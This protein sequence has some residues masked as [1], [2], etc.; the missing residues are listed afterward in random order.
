MAPQ[1][2]LWRVT[3][4]VERTVPANNELGFEHVDLWHGN[5]LMDGTQL[6]DSRLESFWNWLSGIGFDLL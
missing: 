2:L 4:A 1:K 5:T 6:T 3:E